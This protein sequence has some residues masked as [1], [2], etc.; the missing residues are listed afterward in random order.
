MGSRL[1]R[2]EIEKRIECNKGTSWVNNSRPTAPEWICAWCVK[3]KE[4]DVARAEWGRREIIG[5]KLRERDSHRP[6]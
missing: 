6:Q 4:I 2:H 3:Y 1:L 5:N